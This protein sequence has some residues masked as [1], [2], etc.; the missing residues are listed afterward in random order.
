[1]PEDF[2]PLAP[3]RL[4]NGRGVTLDKISM[5]DLLDY[6]IH[7]KITGDNTPLTWTINGQ[8]FNGGSEDSHDLVNTPPDKTVWV[9]IYYGTQVGRVHETERDA[10]MNAMSSLFARVKVVVEEGEGL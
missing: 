5:N 8:K 1:M 9:N 6:P 7:G 10:V 3:V 2:N 4:R